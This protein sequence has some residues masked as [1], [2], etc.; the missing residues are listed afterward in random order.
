[1]NKLRHDYQAYSKIHYEEKIQSYVEAALRD[2]ESALER[3]ELEEMPRHV[4]IIQS[5]TKERFALEDAS[6]KDEAAQYRVRWNK[7]VDEGKDPEEE[8][9]R[10]N[11]GKEDEGDEEEEEEDERAERLRIERLRSYRE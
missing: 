5:V 8:E 7:A 4:T 11:R 9:E 1:M 2:C 10:F 3:G 6:V